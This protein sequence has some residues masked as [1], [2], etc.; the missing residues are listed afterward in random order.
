MSFCYISYTYIYT[1]YIYIYILSS[2]VTEATSFEMELRGHKQATAHS[3]EHTKKFESFKK[4]FRDDK[5]RIRICFIIPK[6]KTEIVRIGF[7]RHGNP[8]DRENVELP[9]QVS[10]LTSSCEGDKGIQVLL[11]F[12][13]GTRRTHWRQFLTW[14]SEAIPVLFRPCSLIALRPGLYRPPPQAI[15]AVSAHSALVG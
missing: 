5:I 13:S 6:K 4:N 1:S 10:P 11:P 9:K 3:H 7:G 2:I 14:G 12:S 8:L 15:R